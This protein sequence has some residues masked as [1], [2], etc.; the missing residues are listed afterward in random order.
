MYRDSPYSRLKVSSGKWTEHA[1][2]AFLVDPRIAI[3][4]V[5]RFPENI[6]LKSEVTQLVEVRFYRGHYI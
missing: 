4:L 6:A 3:S 5:S 1:K 2:T